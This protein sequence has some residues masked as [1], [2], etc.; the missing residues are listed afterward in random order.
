MNSKI[1]LKSVFS[2]MHL[3]TV[4]VEPLKCTLHSVN[5][6]IRIIL[7]SLFLRKD[8][9]GFPLGG[10]YYSNPNE[11]N[12]KR[13]KKKKRQKTK[14]H[15]KKTSERQKKDKWKKIKEKSS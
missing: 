5:T 6:P 2:P 9:K 1:D 11:K 10:D 14:K 3:Q 4:L 8:F 15:K 13:Q 7:S 12:K